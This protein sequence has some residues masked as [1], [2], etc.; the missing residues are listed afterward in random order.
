MVWVCKYRR[1]V[2]KPGVVEY[3]KKLMPKLLR[4]I[5]GCE[6]EQIGFDKDHVH[7][8]MTIPPR[9]MLKQDVFETDPYCQEFKAY[10]I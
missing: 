1:R 5:P 4:S 3:I 6:I 8:V 7:F 9:Y 2:L 10:E